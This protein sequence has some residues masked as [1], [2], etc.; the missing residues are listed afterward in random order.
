MR[1]FYLQLEALALTFLAPLAMYYTLHSGTALGV[2]LWSATAL[3]A[4][5]ALRH[6]NWRVLWHGPQG[7]GH[8]TPAFVRMMLWRWLAATIGMVL[9]LLWL[10]P[11]RLFGFVSERPQ[12]WLMVMLFYPLLS[13][14]PQE[15]IYRSFFFL[16]YRAAFSP[17]LLMATSAVAFALLH[18][19]MNNWV[20]VFLS[21]IGGF[22]FADSYRRH[23]SLKWVTIEHALYGCTL[24]T[25]GLGWYFYHGAWR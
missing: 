1:P 22:I 10:D 3:C 21:I 8:V 16:R 6:E 14:L 5:Y 20:A 24:F 13:A 19:V 4:W 15:V 18:V 2:A 7:G 12:L 17:A 25:V 23:G 11:G 9:F